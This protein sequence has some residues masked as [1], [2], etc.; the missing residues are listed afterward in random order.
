MVSLYWKALV[1][2]M[3]DMVDGIFKRGNMLQSSTFH[4]LIHQ[5]SN[6]LLII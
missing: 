3:I 4:N 1:Y 2:E 6:Y 5:H